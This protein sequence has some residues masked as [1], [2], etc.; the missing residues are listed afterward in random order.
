MEQQMI[1]ES[2]YADY[3]DDRKE[4]EEM[5]QLLINRLLEDSSLFLETNNELAPEEKEKEAK[6]ALRVL[7]AL[8][9]ENHITKA[10]EDI[11][12]L[13]INIY[14]ARM[15]I[16]AQALGV[17]DEVM[18]IVAIYLANGLKHRRSSYSDFG[19]NAKSDFLAELEL[20]KLMQ[21]SRRTN[22]SLFGVLPSNYE[23]ALD[24]RN[25]L[26]ERMYDIYGYVNSDNEG[27]TDLI[28]KSCLSGLVDFLYIRQEHGW[29]VN[30]RDPCRR[31]IN[32]SS[33]ALPEKYVFAI[34]KT[35]SLT[36]EMPEGAVRTLY[37]LTY[38][39]AF[40]SY[41]ILYELAP[42]LIEKTQKEFFHYEEN[43]YKLIT[44]TRFNGIL[45]HE[46]YTPINES[47][48]KITILTNWLVA[49]TLNISKDAY[50]KEMVKVFEFVASKY[51]QKMQE[52]ELK[53]L[54]MKF[55]RKAFGSNIPN[56][57]KGKNLKVFFEVI[58]KMSAS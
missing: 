43:S 54:Y 18:T 29:Y 19:I 35:I 27:N 53:L 3:K 47:Q 42:Q 25:E 32:L 11:L 51:N 44:R 57:S 46:E 13:D 30:F 12:T 5:E 48:K 21:E 6:R 36:Y 55:L 28:L 37:V 58:K 38:A 56:L 7:G 39:T 52:E 41:D 33:V 23:K 40:T 8:D 1:E 14:F 26:D 50:P 17:A 4:N 2:C 45:I 16:T 24:I 15:L 34:P 49:N 31:K 20:F 22:M 9:N 10:G